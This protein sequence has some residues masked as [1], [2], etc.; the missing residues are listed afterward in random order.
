MRTSQGA[1]PVPAR[2]PR[3]EESGLGDAQRS[4]NPHP[5]PPSQRQNGTC[6]DCGRASA[7]WL[8]NVLRDSALLVGAVMC[9]FSE[10]EGLGSGRDPK[11]RLWTQTWE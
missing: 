8:K 1:C 6:N 5:L 2:K 7:L 3:A 4:C 11:C 10:L 9:T